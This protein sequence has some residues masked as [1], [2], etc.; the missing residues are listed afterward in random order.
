MYGGAVIDVS[1]GDERI[2]LRARAKAEALAV[3]RRELQRR[4]TA[5]G[6]VKKGARL[7][8][9]ERKQ[10]RPAARRAA[11]KQRA[12]ER[13]PEAAPAPPAQAREDAVGQAEAEALRKRKA[14]ERRLVNAAFVQNKKEKGDVLGALEEVLGTARPSLLSQ[15]EYMLDARESR[16]QAAST[17]QGRVF[18]GDKGGGVPARQHQEVPPPTI[19][20]DAY[21]L[22][23]FTCRPKQGRSRVFDGEGREIVWPWE[24]GALPTA[25]RDPLPIDG[26]VDEALSKA[27]ASNGRLTTGV[28]QW[29]KFCSA[30][31]TTPFRPL[32]PSAPL[33]VKL[34]EQWLVMRF[35]CTQVERGVAPDTAMGYLSAVQGWHLRTQHVKLA[36]GMK[37]ELLG[38][39]AKGLR[40]MRPAGGRAVRRG[41]SPQDLRRAMDLCLDPFDPHQQNLRA[42]LALGFQGLLRGC[43]TACDGNFRAHAD[44]ARGDIACLT[45]E[46][47]AVMTEPSKKRR[48]TGGK[49]VPLVVGAGGKYIDAVA[50]MQQLLSVDPTPAGM[51]AITPMF[52]GRNGE[53]LQIGELR[54]VIKKLM[55]VLGHDPSQ[56]GAH[57]LRIGGATALFA[58]GA[59]PIVI[60]T[61]GRWSSDCYRLYVRACFNQTLEWTTKAGSIVVSDIAQ[62]FE[63]VDSY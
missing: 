31:G 63:E 58:A 46:R 62:E 5:S 59:D 20:S 54:D 8:L 28:R 52:K 27:T 6:P 7:K 23:A 36:S 18:A 56:F 33:W 34:E 24:N 40:K 2:E 1:E 39:L 44:M 4:R 22:D 53:A 19:P 12:D 43:E 60:R 21:L 17:Q 51:E 14:T 41:V 38:E 57:S 29:L 35:V 9:D 32:D 48:H 37:L 15:V 47:L 25:V 61:M 16:E 11:T 3:A 42:A 55:G 30:I 10:K 13:A 45:S 26:M 49:T 50:E